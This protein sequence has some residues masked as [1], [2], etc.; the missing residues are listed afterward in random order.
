MIVDTSAII[1]YLQQEPGHAF[2][3]SQLT[4]ADRAL[5]SAATL[6]EAQI[7]AHGRFGAEWT[8]DTTGGQVC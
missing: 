2:V 4:A 8:V 3:R 1:T 5:I 7:V 6:A